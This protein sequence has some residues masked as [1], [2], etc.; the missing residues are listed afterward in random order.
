VWGE[1]KGRV[2]EDDEERDSPGPG[3]LKFFPPARPPP[4][5][6]LKEQR[7]K[8]PDPKSRHP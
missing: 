5:I 4:P 3:D 7:D 1:W 6:N 2:G 8:S